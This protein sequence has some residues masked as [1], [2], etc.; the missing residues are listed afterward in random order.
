MAPT[1][2]CVPQKGDKLVQFRFRFH[3]IPDHFC[4]C[5]PIYAASQESGLTAAERAEKIY[6]MVDAV[7]PGSYAIFMVVLVYWST[8]WVWPPHSNSGT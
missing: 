4:R 1:I 7:S 8:G 6:Q 2:F 3:P 5:P